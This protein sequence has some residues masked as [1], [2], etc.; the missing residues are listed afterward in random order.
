MT[1][2][3]LVYAAG[4]ERV[5]TLVVRLDDE[6]ISTT[7]AACPGW[8]VHDVVAH[9]AGSV[10]DAVT[11]RLEG[12]GS[13]RWTAAQ[14]ESRRGVPVKEIVDD[15]TQNSPQFEDVL[16]AIGPPLAPIAVSDLFQHEQDVRSA[17]DIQGGRDLE[18]LLLAIEAY[19]P[20][21]SDRVA[22]AGLEALHLSAGTHEFGTGDGTPGAHLTAEP[23]ELARLLGGRRTLDE[24]RA[25]HWEGEA[26]PYVELMSAYGIPPASLGER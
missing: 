8:T 16:R 22:R 24:I 25:L 26:A 3:G 23:F 5:S 9:L 2:Y 19:L 15:W 10:A 17:L 13:D 1:D 7:V 18:V 12:V 21:L 20:G 6:Q 14:V 11:G 4:R